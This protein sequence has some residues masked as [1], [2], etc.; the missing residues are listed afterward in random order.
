MIEYKFQDQQNSEDIFS[1]ESAMEDFICV[2]FVLDRNIANLSTNG[3]S[4]DVTS[5]IE[6]NTLEACVVTK[7]VALEACLITEGAPMEA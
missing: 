6:G 5:V 7:G 1:F 4:L 2:V 3:T